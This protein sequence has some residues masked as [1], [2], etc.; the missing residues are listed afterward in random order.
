MSK[1]ILNSIQNIPAKFIGTS[2][3]MAIDSISIDSR[4][5]QNGSKT[6]FFALVGAN[7]DAHLY[8]KNLIASGVQNFVVTH[9]PEDCEGK[10]NFYVVTNTLLA[11]QQFAAAYRSLFDFPVIGLTGSNGKTIVKEWLNFLLSPDYNVIRS[12][13][14]YN[15]QIGVPLSVIAINEKHNLG[16]FEA[17]ISTVSEMEKLEKI[18]KPTI[19]ILTNIGT[20]H[21]EGFADISD[22][23]K[24]KLK[25]FQDVQV[26]IYHKNPTIDS[27]IRPD[28]TVFCWSYSDAKASVLITK[29]GVLD[30]TVLTVLQNNNKFDIKIPFQDEASIENAISCLMVLLYFKYDNRTIQNRMELLYPVEMRLKVKNGINN[31]SIIDDSY[32]SDF[33][34]LKIALDFL[35]SQKQYKKKTVI[36]SDIFQSGLPNDVL[37]AKVAELIVSNRITRVIGI[38]ETISAFKNKFANCSTFQNTAAFVA[39]FENLD[40]GNETILIKGARSFQFEEIVY[41]LEEKTHETVLEINLNAISYNLNFFKSKLLPKVKIMVMVKAFGYGNGGLE[42]AKLLE[43]HKVDYL[44]VA[45]ADE[46]ISLKN[47]G[48]NLPIMVLNPENTSFSA[49]IQHQLEPEIYCLKGLYA[50]LK[51]AKQKNLKHFP[52]HIKFDTGMHRLGFE[53]NT[54]DELIAALR[55]NSTVQI[56]SILSH[57]ATSD[58]LEHMDFAHSQ[59]NLFE[60]V[61]SKLMSELQ[62]KPLRHILNTS[63]ISNFMDSQYDMVRLGIGLYGVSNDAQEQKQLENVG[64]LKSVISQIRTIAAGESVGYGRRFVAEKPTKI[65]TIPIGY[66]DGISRG[67]G[68]GL[69]FVMIKNTKAYIVGS[70]CMDMLMVDVTGVECKEGDSILIFGENPTVSFIAQKLNTIPY[71][72]LTSISQRVKRV[73]YR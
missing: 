1:K 58:D 71:E 43:H 12:P 57:L 2:S 33:Q 70:I 25:L 21:D 67:W 60:K 48:I 29:K 64:T 11:L 68:D 45:F 38:G 10:A 32:S 9:I 27:L 24:E 42:I 22:K 55:G 49:I 5:L 13:K 53:E 66:A 28:T 51:I 47:G 69:G 30:K 54:L 41:L 44:G 36:L 35:E 37:Y 15:S 8:L 17:G 52:I 19:G 46:G 73:F 7:T 59:I 65:A 62:I 50:F 4:S 72:I 3:T 23:I 40:F 20:A 6:L 61:S 63:G 26:I 56:K 39:D 31:S 16:I 14:S 34:S 18:I